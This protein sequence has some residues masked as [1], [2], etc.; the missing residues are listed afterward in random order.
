MS[1]TTHGRFSL[2]P[3]ALARAFDRMILNACRA[4][5]ARVDNGLLH[6]TMPSGEQAALGRIAAG[7]KDAAEAALAVNRYAVLPK[8]LARA[9]IGFAEAYSAGDIDSPDLAAVIRFFVDNEAALTRAGRGSFKV[10]SSDKRWH[11]QRDNT[12][13]GSRSNIAAHYDLGNAFYALWLDPS[14]TYS[15]AIFAGVDDTLEH[16]QTR[17]LDRIIAALD[18]KPGQTVLE[19]GC[20]WGA[21]AERIAKTTGAHVTAITLSAEQLSYARQRIAQAGLEDRVDLRFQDYRDVTGC[22]DRIVSIEMI[23]AVGEAHWPTYFSTL[24]Q[25]LTPG[26]HAIVQA[27]VIAPERYAHYRSKPDFIQRYI[28]PGGMLPTEPILARQAQL[29]D[30]TYAPV[31]RFGQ[32]YVRT[33]AAW[34]ERFEAAWP[35]LADLGFDERFRRMWRYYLIYCEVAFERRVTDVGLYRF[36]KLQRPSTEPAKAT[37]AA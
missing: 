19:I 1:S 28:F 11:A 15:S 21:L 30:L 2:T 18:L 37:P 13:D 9:S 10:R 3:R 26:G 31:D 36:D 27:I 32:S 25:R 6:L 23:E 34:R 7:R 16:A 24:Q 8:S 22:F 14:L 35:Q 5:T 20:G 29:A 17:K 12:R 4:A 33:L